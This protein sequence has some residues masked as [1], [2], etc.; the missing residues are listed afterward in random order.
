VRP[1]LTILFLLPIL[2]SP[3]PVAA[4]QVVDTLDGVA[5]ARRSGPRT[6][7]RYAPVDSPLAAR[8]QALLESEARLPGLPLSVPRGVTVLL[9]HSRAAFDAVT[10]GSVPDWRAGVSI[11]D[12]DL[13]VL[14]TREG[15]SLVDA[16]GRRVLRHEWA[17]LALHQYLGALLV[18]RWFDEGYA[19]WASGGWD[20]SEAWR[21]RLMLAFGRAPPLDSLSLDWPRDAMSADAAYL[22]AASAVAFL[23]QESGERGVTLFLGRWREDRS[24]E[25]ALRRT[26]GLTSSQLEEDWRR[27]VRHR[28][29]W[30]F[31]FSHSAVFWMALALVLLGMMRLRQS[32]NRE[33][34]ARLRAGE[35][36][37]RPAWWAADADEGG[38]DLPPGVEPPGDSHE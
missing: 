11:P 12:R 9:A 4:A 26:F 21:L 23:V 20:A 38:P 6:V 35:P 22:L 25:H 1:T 16:D 33:R 13:M 34:L 19:Q 17:H 18:P 10:G 30:L 37:D 8:V 7:V 15:R 32:R 2:V 28:Y 27:D 29:G 3:C 36:P 14:P 5:Y 24:F 31:V